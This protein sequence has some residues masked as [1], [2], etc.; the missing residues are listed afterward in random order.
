MLARNH[1]GRL[2]FTNGRMVDIEPLG[3]VM[4]GDWLFARSA[5]GA[6]FGALAHR[7]YAAFEVDEVD[8]PFDWRSVVAHGT[9][10]LLPKDG[11]PQE[12][13]AHARAVRLIQRVMPN[14]FTKG[15]PAPERE[16]V[17]GLRIHQFEGRQARS[18]S[19]RRKQPNAK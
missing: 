3:Y 18:A 19:A 4:S 5:P 1:I 15:D 17:Y 14:A 12:R 2:A 10:S 8:G 13:R 16:I 7:P 6:K 11:S 9:I